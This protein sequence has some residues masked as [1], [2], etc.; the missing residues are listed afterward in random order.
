MNRKNVAIAAGVVGLVAVSV[1]AG[2][3]LA[4]GGV[5]R[6]DGRVIEPEPPV[7]QEYEVE[8]DSYLAHRPTDV[9][10]DSGSGDSSDSQ[11]GDSSSAQ[12]RGPNGGSD[13]ANNGS[14]MTGGSGSGDSTAGGG[15]SPSSGG[16]GG[17]SSSNGA[18]NGGVLTPDPAPKPAPQ[19]EVEP[20]PQPQPQPQPENVA[21]WVVKVIPATYMKGVALNANFVITFSEPMDRASAEAAFS[22][23]EPTPGKFS[24]NADSTVMTFNPDADFEYNDVPAWTLTNTAKDAQGKALKN[25]SVGEFSVMKLSKVVLKGQAAFDGTVYAPPVAVVGPKAIANENTFDVGT[26]QRGFISFD[27][28]QLPEATTKIESAVLKVYQTDHDATAYSAATGKLN[29]QSVTYGT[30]DAGDWGRAMNQFCLGGCA[31]LQSTLSTSA[32]NGWKTVDALGMVSLDWGMREERNLR[33]QFR[34]VFANENNGEG[35]KVSASFASGATAFAP[36]LEIEYVH[37]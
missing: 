31:N 24:W 1:L 25:K 4:R 5:E 26:W 9:T 10:A 37:P 18:G 33:S 29:V 20:Q 35:P 3:L 30:L 22:F 27:L 23:D 21:P 11:S 32:V 36:Q 13:G 14:S 2:T 15:V 7:V 6:A 28:G 34:L 19:P 17:G 8:D 16:Q 12:N